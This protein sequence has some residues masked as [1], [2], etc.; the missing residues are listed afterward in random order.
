MVLNKTTVHIKHLQEQVS[1]QVLTA[2]DGE[3]DPIRRGWNRTIDHHPAVILVARNAEDVA[4]GVRFAAETG[5]GVAVQ[6]TGHGIQHPADDALL[7]VTTR[8]NAVTVNAAARTARIE[9]GAV[10]QQ[11]VEQTTPHGLAPLLGSSPHVGV[12]GYTLGGGI[13]WL[14]RQYG[15][16]V[17]SVRAI[18]VV[19][20]DGLLCHTSAEEH[21]DLFWGLR[22]GKST[23]GIVTA[24]EI[25]L[26]PV[27][28]F[29]GGSLVYSG[30]SADAALRFFR[31]WTQRAPDALTSSIAI[32][33]FP[34]LPVLPEPMRGKKQVIVR[35]VYLGE[36]AEGEA[37]IRQWVDWHAPEANTFKVMP[38][39]DIGLVSNDPVE[40]SH[41]YYANELLNDLPDA[42]L[43]AMTHYTL[44][45]ASPLMVSELRHAGG[46]IARVPADANAVGNRDAQY[47]L[48]FA[49]PAFTA[50]MLETLQAQMKRYKDALRPL[51]SGGVY[52]NFVS[53]PETAGSTENA[54]LPQSYQRLVSLKTQYD[55]DNVF[56]FGFYRRAHQHK[57]AS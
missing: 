19:T 54:F 14:A 50:E 42:V 32:L 16:A 3:Y 33:K 51:V 6:S 1:G 8:M 20:A 30:D 55:P 26:V 10:W 43:D 46:A 11:V 53:G 2:D 35:A 13:G 28:Q 49:G 17:D 4:A 23:L 36:A 38:F 57:L 21:R 12:V 18:D 29:Y 40:P 9:A 45:A 34:N 31:E 24:L 27:A 7:I 37:L 41:T 39:T 15:L 52:M 44:D 48:T 22:G 5:L 25:N 47:Y 56:R